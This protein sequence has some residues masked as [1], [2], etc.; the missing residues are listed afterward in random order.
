[1]KGRLAGKGSY[2]RAAFVKAGQLECDR[3]AMLELLT[4]AVV[5]ADSPAAAFVR[6]AAAD[7]WDR[8][9]SA[10]LENELRS[11]LT[12]TAAEGAI[13][14]FALNL[15][16]LLMQPPVRGHVTMGLD[17]GYRHGCKVAVIDATGKVLDTT[18][19]YP[20]FANRR[21]EA[22]QTLSALIA[23]HHVAHLAVGNGTASRET[24]QMVVELIRTMPQQKLSYAMVNE[25]GASVYSASELAATEFPQFDVNL[26]SAVSIARR[27]Q[28]PLAELVKIDPKAIGVGQ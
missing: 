8:L 5:R 1:M 23:R 19:V 21:Q 17:P 6:A 3:A 11:M 15:R 18:V 10:S 20:T 7:A 25:A 26:R 28:D 4:R 9:L 13:H 24:E 14:N 22:I 16:P 12:D 2:V 27:L